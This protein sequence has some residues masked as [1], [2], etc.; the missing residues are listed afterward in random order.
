M[1]KKKFGSSGLNAVEVA[2]ETVSASVSEPQESSQIVAFAPAQSPEIAVSPANATKAEQTTQ[3]SPSILK[4]EATSA[5]QSAAQPGS[6]QK[7]SEEP[8]SEA[9][10]ENTKG[11]NILLPISI[12]KR[13]STMKLD[14]EDETLKSLGLKA[15]IEFLDKNK[16]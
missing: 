8:A 4:T 2:A 11:L 14:V 13:L 6:Q 7:Q 15:I 5:V 12:Y 16:Y 3:A 10:V 9:K 1:A